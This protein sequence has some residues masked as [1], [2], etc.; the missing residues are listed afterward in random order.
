SGSPETWMPTVD[1]TTA[2]S[3]KENG[4]LFT[5]PSNRI[6]LRLAG[7]SNTY[8]PSL[9]VVTVGGVPGSS[10]QPTAHCRVSPEVFS[11]CSRTWD[12]SFGSMLMPKVAVPGV[13]IPASYVRAGE[14]RQ[15]VS[16]WSRVVS[17]PSMLVGQP[18]VITVP[19][20]GSIT[21][22]S[23]PWILTAILISFQR[24]DKASHDAVF[25]C[26]TAVVSACAQAKSMGS[27]TPKTPQ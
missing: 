21:Y 3:A 17:I 11:W 15:V 10:D 24:W 9:S 23:V 25:G 2:F 7:V 22:R 18:T 19:S 14:L 8:S 12:A 13:G 5:N 27:D 6:Q 20:S 16:I 4:K 1:S 26:L